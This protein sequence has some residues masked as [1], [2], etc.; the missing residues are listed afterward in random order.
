M[1]Y[2]FFSFYRDS[3]FIGDISSLVE[4]NRAGIY[5]RNIL[6]PIY[7]ESLES[8][9][10]GT[11]HIK[12]FII[13]IPPQSGSILFMINRYALK[14]GYVNNI[15]F[16][17]DQMIINNMALSLTSATFFANSHYVVAL[18]VNE[19]FVVIHDDM[20]EQSLVSFKP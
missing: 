11:E 5:I 8:H 14:P 19:D 13:I 16:P 20:K 9:Q 1:I 12:R 4:N 10:C 7:H 15:I 3:K 18:F 2:F 6:F 17:D